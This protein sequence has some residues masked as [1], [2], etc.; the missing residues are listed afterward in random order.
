MNELPLLWSVLKNLI[1]NGIITLASNPVRI[2]KRIHRIMRTNSVTI[3]N[4]HKVSVRKENSSTWPPLDV[5]LFENLIVYLKLNYHFRT[6]STLFHEPED[7]PII[8][9]SFDDGYKNFIE[10]AVPLLEKYDVKVNQNVLPGCS[11]DGMPPLNVMAQDF[12]GSAPRVLLNSFEIPNLPVSSTGISRNEFGNLVSKHIKYLPMEEQ[13]ALK[14][15]LLEYFFKFA[16]YTFTPMMSVDEIVQI[17]KVHEIGMHS[18][19]HASMGVETDEYFREDLASCIKFS[20]EVLKTNSRIYAFPNGSYNPQQL[21]ISSELGYQ[22]M[23]LVDESFATPEGQTFKRFNFDAANM[24][25]LRYRV[26]G[27]FSKIPQ[28]LSP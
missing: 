8:I 27:N 11:Y 25:E 20:E 23:L 7:K 14:P 28:K 15:Y 4:L 22:K 5:E 24:S 2:Q 9:L 1:K 17:S 16:E 18:W 13:K 21:R 3:L 10:Y 19:D 12:I 6:F 26:T